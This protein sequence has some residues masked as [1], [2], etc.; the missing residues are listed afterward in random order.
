MACDDIK[1]ITSIKLDER[2]YQFEESSMSLNYKEK[3]WTLLIDCCGCWS[4]HQNFWVVFFPLLP[5]H[6][7]SLNS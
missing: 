5:L 3:K 6:I 2:T 7:I 4:F 1:P